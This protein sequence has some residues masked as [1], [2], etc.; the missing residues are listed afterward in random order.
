VFRAGLEFN[1]PLLADTLD[2]HSGKLP[3][4]WGLFDI[5]APNVVMSA[6]MP[7][8]DGHGVIVRVYEA[9]GEP[10]PDVTI[11]FAEGLAGASEVNLMEES[12]QPMAV[13]NNAI[14]FAL[15]PFQI[16]TFRIQLTGAMP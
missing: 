13:Q 16:K 7:A 8:E 12:L 6:F 10:A 5:S 2:Q 1:N 15:R 3:K 14:H 11:H 9:A 4:K